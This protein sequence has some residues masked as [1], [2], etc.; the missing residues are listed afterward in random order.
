MVEDV[1]V[2]EENMLGDEGVGFKQAMSTLD[3]GRISIAALG[4]GMAQG[5]FEASVKYAK[6]RHTFGKPLIEHQAIGFKLADMQVEI[7]AGVAA[8]CGAVSG[9]II[10]RHRG[11]H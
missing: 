3:G 4:L 2:P 10:G 7:E 11:R 5:A 8:A 6:A 9:W 1:K